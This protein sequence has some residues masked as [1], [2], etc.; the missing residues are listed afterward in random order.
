MQG[1]G[2]NFCLNSDD[3]VRLLVKDRI[4]ELLKSYSLPETLCGYNLGFKSKH[5]QE[6]LNQSDEYDYYKK[7]NLIK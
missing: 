4:I 1:E 2:R 3:E 5:F 6:C 7:F